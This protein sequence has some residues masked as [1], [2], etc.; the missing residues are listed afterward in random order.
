[1]S[2]MRQQ[3]SAWQRLGTQHDGTSILAPYRL[4]IP[5]GQEGITQALTKECG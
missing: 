1:M 3:W 5:L 4:Q 2:Q